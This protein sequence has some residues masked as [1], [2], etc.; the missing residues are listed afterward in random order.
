MDGVLVQTEPLKAEAHAVATRCFGGEVAPAFYA[1]I[2]GRPVEEIG[3]AFLVAGKAHGDMGH[4]LALYDQVYHRFVR[5]HL[6][7]TPGV[8]ELLQHLKQRG[9]RLGLVTSDYALTMR[10]IIE[11]TDLTQFFDTTIARDDVTHIKPAPDGYLAALARLELPAHA[12]VVIEDSE[13][14][15]QAAVGAG[16]PVLALRHSFN[17]HHNFSLAAQI[18]NSFLNPCSLIEMIET[19]FLKVYDS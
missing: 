10:H 14:G 15:V 19:I 12:A 4:Y 7:P 11:R 8:T 18:V 9:W 17:T 5:T 3:H 13:S 2:M 1:T 16:I 6:A